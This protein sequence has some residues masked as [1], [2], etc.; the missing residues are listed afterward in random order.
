MP[1][2]QGGIDSLS[3][4]TFSGRLLSQAFEENL[5]LFAGQKFVVVRDRVKQD[6][7]IA[8]VQVCAS[9]KRGY[10][11]SLSSVLELSP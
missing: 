5:P 7:G 9:V 11:H 8:T 2:H 3:V 6:L 1:R 4:E 10:Q